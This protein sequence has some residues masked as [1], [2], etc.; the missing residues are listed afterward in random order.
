MPD[1]ERRITLASALKAPQPR[2]PQGSAVSYVDRCGSWPMPMNAVAP[3]VEALF[4]ALQNIQP[5]E[6]RA[7][8][9]TSNARVSLNDSQVGAAVRLIQALHGDAPVVAPKCGPWLVVARDAIVALPNVDACEALRGAG[10]VEVE[11]P[12]EAVVAS[13]EFESRLDA[14]RGSR[15]HSLHERKAIGL[16]ISQEEHGVRRGILS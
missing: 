12:T 15:R 13:R 5:A 14:E 10:L 2:C 3:L 7:L 4:A 8:A 6:I 16:R 11:H 9:D 1:I